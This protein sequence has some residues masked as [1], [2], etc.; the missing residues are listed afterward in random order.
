MSQLLHFGLESAESIFT[1]K[2]PHSPRF[3]QKNAQEFQN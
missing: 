2:P 1:D 3:L